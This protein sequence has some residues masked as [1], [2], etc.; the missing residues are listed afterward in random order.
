VAS[1]AP[2]RPSLVAV[3]ALRSDPS[4]PGVTGRAPG[5]DGNHKSHF[6]VSAYAA[7]CQAERPPGVV[8]LAPQGWHDCVIDPQPHVG[9][10]EF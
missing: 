10:G 5:H 6:L 3:M 8:D 9:S 7:A 1:G 4:F 2:S